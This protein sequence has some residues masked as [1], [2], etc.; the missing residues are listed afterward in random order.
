MI[1][2]GIQELLY[3]F[4]IVILTGVYI[5]IYSSHVPEFL[6]IETIA[7]TRK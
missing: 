2:T 7:N 1:L 6:L 4:T 5:F 3:I